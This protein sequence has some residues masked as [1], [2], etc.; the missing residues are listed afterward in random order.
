MY[1]PTAPA[2]YGLENSGFYDN[3]AE[4]YE[5]EDNYG[6]WNERKGNGTSAERPKEGDTTGTG[7]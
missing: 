3:L 2:H 4:E 6:Q 7:E 5:K 1:A